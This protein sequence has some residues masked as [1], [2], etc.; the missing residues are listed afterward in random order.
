M[1]T[2]FFGVPA[3]RS[4]EDAEK[5]DGL[6]FARFFRY[7]LAHGFYI[8]PSRFEANFLSAAHTQ[9]ELERFVKLV[10]AFRE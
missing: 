6:R 4:F 2:L 10:G 7:M 9:R 1:F 5:S 8:S 3:V